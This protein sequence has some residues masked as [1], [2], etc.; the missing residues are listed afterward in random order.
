MRSGVRS[1]TLFIFTTIRTQ[2][3][4]ATFPVPGVRAFLV[5]VRGLGRRGPFPPAPPCP[6]LPAPRGAQSCSPSPPTPNPWPLVA[7]LVPRT[8]PTM[9]ELQLQ[10]LPVELPVPLVRFSASSRPGSEHSI[11]L[12][13]GLSV[14]SAPRDFPQLVSLKII[15]S[16][17]LL[18]HWNSS[19]LLPCGLVNRRSSPCWT[20][21]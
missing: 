4:R 9:G 16:A 5:V 11:R 6:V 7:G 18:R 1:V 2:R 8:S 15:P 19:S 20:L 14:R 13:P 17:W 3:S 21:T 12:Q 10:V